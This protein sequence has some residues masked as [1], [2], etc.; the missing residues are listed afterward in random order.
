MK[1]NYPPLEGICKI[2][3]EKGLCTGCNRLELENFRG[4][5]ECKHFPITKTHK[6]MKGIQLKIG[7]K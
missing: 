5:K 4:L 1:Y 6:E 2:V 3:I 7:D